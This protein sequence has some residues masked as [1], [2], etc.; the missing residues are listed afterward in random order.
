MGHG[1]FGTDGD[2]RFV[3]A[4]E[5]LAVAGFHPQGLRIF[6]MAAAVDHLD[7]AMLRQGFDALAQFVENR[8]LPAAQ[9][10]QVDL[11]RAE[12]DAAGR[13]LCGFAQ[14]FGGVEQCFRG[15]AA[16]VQTNAAEPGVLFD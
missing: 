2:D 4:N 5:L 11:G 13:R 15:N 9:F 1:R 12:G 10:V 7:V 8:I 6:E 14:Q 3:V 16:D